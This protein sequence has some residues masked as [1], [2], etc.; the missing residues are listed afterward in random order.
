MLE[1]HEQ[2]RQVINYLVQPPDRAELLQLLH[3]LGMQASELVR[4][5]EPL[6][7]ELYEGREHSEEEWLQMMLKHPI[8]IER[9][10]LVKDGKAIVGRPVEKVKTFFGQ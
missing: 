5:N 10:I 4:R 9:P 7:K 6:F 1:E 2:A 8:L 3:M